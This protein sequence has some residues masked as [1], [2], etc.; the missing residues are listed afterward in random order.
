MTTLL[1]PEDR[2]LSTLNADGSRRWLTPKVSRGNKWKKRRLVGWIL[3]AIFVTLPHIHVGGKQFFFMNVAA[4]EF[5]VFGQT[6]QR[7]D[8]LLLAL[9]LILVGLSIFFLTAMFGRVWCGWGCP[10]TVYMEFVFRPIQRMFDGKP[11]RTGLGK[12][13]GKLPAAPRTLLRW[14]VVLAL[15]FFLAN[16]FL[17]YFVGSRQLLDWVTSSPLEHPVGFG[18]VVFVTGLMLFDFGFFREQL[19][20]VACPYGRMQS[21]L[22]DK[23]SLIVGYDENRGEPR[24]FRKG[25]AK[26]PQGDLSLKVVG[27]GGAATLEEPT[28]GD[29]VDCN[30]CVKVCPTGIDI[31]DGLQLECIHCA[32]CIDACNEVMD[33]L[34]RQPGLIRYSS[35][36]G[37]QT[38]QWKRLR[39]RTIIYPLL[40]GIIASVLVTLLMTR[41]PAEVAVVRGP[42]L[43]F[44]TLPDGLIANQAR[45]RITNRT[46]E[47]RTYTIS[48]EPGVELRGETVGL[49]IE[50]GATLSDRLTIVAEPSYFAGSG[51]SKLTPIQVED[52]MGYSK[53]IKMRV[54]GPDGPGADAAGAPIGTGETTPGAPGTPAEPSA[55]GDEG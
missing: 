39:P 5:T 38:G 9:S 55:A 14:A 31:R 48:G 27:E 41:A 11:G 51:G 36:D 8:T 54:R 22:L 26:K 46:P 12:F 7:T 21:V 49:V 23:N 16:T 13:L 20:I 50:P 43:P 28:F 19:C 42:G 47:P 18:I 34:G 45:V 6:F 44:Y 10:Q 33:K 35:Q 37:L 32:Q 17:S 1:Q 40:L 29:C 53:T 25:K 2:V 30:N 52:D 4:G 15:C 24:G 3:I